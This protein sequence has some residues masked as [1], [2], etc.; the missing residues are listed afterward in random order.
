LLRILDKCDRLS[1]L[2]ETDREAYERAL[3]EVE[4]QVLG[5]LA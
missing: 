3:N 5:H 1:D 4:S 2:S